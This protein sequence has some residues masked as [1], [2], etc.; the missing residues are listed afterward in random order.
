MSQGTADNPNPPNTVKKQ[1]LINSINTINDSA[2]SSF[3]F[4]Y[5]IGFPLV[6]FNFGS[7]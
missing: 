3:K 2:K 6:S 1:E 7:S 4:K 5:F